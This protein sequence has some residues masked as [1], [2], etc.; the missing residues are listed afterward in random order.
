MMSAF[1]HEA[2]VWEQS[3]QDDDGVGFVCWSRHRTERAAR[4]AAVRYA[5]QR[6]ALIRAGGS[7][8][9]AGG[10]REMETGATLW[11]DGE[12]VQR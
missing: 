5:R 7:L 6:R 10:L 12:G 9:W 1:T 4:R 8:S 2:G 3:R 11:L